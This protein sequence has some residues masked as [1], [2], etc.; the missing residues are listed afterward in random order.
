M[1]TSGTE[2]Q[3]QSFHDDDGPHTEQVAAPPHPSL[4]LCS[5]PYDPLKQGA[6]KS[7]KMFILTG[8]HHSS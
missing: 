4:A 6:V 8:D 5:L 3:G 1:T 2:G 7:A